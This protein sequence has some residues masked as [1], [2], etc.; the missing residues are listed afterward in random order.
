MQ[1]RRGTH[2]TNYTVRCEGC[3]KE[4]DCSHSYVTLELDNADHSLA[5]HD[6][7][8]AHFHNQ[9]CIAAALLILIEHRSPTPT[10]GSR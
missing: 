9:A 8:L 10:K 3:G 6:F 5:Q 2:W 7:R 4:L 1:L